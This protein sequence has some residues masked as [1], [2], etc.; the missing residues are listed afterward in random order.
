MTKR[1]KRGGGPTA[2]IGGMLAG[3]DHQIFRTTPPPHE[4]VLKASPV[5]GLSGEGA[6]LEITIPGEDGAPHVH[7]DGDEAAAAEAAAAEAEAGALAGDLPDSE[8]SPS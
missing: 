7:D 3:F 2:A 1:K 8:S 4:L 5:R 6:D